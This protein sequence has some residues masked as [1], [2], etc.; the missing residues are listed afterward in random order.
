VPTN[1]AIALDNI[2]VA[3]SCVAVT[4]GT[5]R[6]IGALHLLKIPSHQG[7]ALLLAILAPAAAYAQPLSFSPPRLLN[8]ELPSLPAPTV[9][10][11]GEVLL[12]VVVTTTGA[13]A[14]P[15]ILRSTPPYTQLVLDS[16]SRW[17]FEP[18]RFLEANGAQVPVEASVCIVAVYRPPTLVNAPTIGEPPRDLRTPSGDVACPI[19]MHVPLHPPQA[20]Q[21]AVLL[22]DIALDERA[23]IVDTRA[24]GPT[25]GFEGAARDALVMWRFRPAMFRGRATGA[26]TFVLFGFRSPVVNP[27]VVSP[28]RDP[29]VSSVP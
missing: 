5:L 6:S 20:L 23:G 1:R 27:P 16:V 14:H 17:Q 18:A 8:A 10:G 7:F 15:V 13:V 2:A 3:L 25:F 22:F 26:S 12:E 11:G 19:S 9:V 28:L 21:G 4:F 24:L 29:G